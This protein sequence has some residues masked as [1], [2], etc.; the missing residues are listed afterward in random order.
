V[1]SRAAGQKLPAVANV[2]E[3]SSKR[4]AASPDCVRSPSS[5]AR[6][7]PCQGKPAE[8]LARTLRRRVEA[9]ATMRVHHLN[10][11]SACPLGGLVM[12][13]FSTASLRGRLTSHCLLLELEHTLVL[14]DTGYG[15][16]DVHDP[17]GRLAEFFLTLNRPELREE[18]T[19]IRQIERLGFDPRDVRHVVISHLD[20]D[21]AGG[22][23]DFP[24]ATVHMLADEQRSAVARKTPLDKLRYRPQQ[25]STREHWRSYEAG[26]GEGWFGFACVRQLEGV[27][28]D[29]LLVPLVG[30]TLGHAGVAV[31]TQGSW[32]FY[33]ADAYFYHAEMDHD[34]PRCTPGLRFYQTMMEKDRKQRLHNQVRLRELAHVHGEQVTVFCAHDVREFERLSG[35]PHSQPVA[36]R[37]LELSVNDGFAAPP[38]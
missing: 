24:H 8:D 1:C 7:E 17:H 34:R 26:A 23:D 12:D 30:H 9:G 36:P 35:R 14:V 33:A 38:R 3:L 2:R 18:M 10:C 22:L 11:V 15:L 21:H 32:L 29:V 28:P 19:A 6:P 13:G 16:R 37:A 25:W 5:L 27:G 4:G 20:F 31:R